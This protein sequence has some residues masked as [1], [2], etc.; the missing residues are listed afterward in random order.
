MQ[1]IKES[2]TTKL[3]PLPAWAWGATLGGSYVVYR[4]I[5]SAQ[6]GNATQGVDTSA[7][8][9]VGTASDFSQG[10]GQTSPGLGGINGST[11]IL[12]NQTDQAPADNV[13]WGKEAVNWLISQGIN[14]LVAADAIGAYLYGT[15][16]QLNATETAALNM[17]LKHFGTPPEGVIQPP[18]TTPIPS[19]TTKPPPKPAV[20][21]KFTTLVPNPPTTSQIT[22]P[23]IHYTVQYG[24]TIQG[25]AAHFYGRSDAYPFIVVANG[26][27]STVLHTGQVLLIKNPR[28]K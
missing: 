6:A 20:A 28:Y 14:P 18:P 5:K 17:A 8:G 23:D 10:F 26:L 16:Q 21:P 15:G 4:Y 27:K 9:D 12:T 7:V 19:P 1:D 24:D 13:T 2:L 3:G 22:H 11:G 25:I